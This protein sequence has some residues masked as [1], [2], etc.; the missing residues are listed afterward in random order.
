MKKI[1]V[2]DDLYAELINISEAMNTQPNAATASPYMYQIEDDEEVI[3][4]EGYG[5]RQEWVEHSSGD[6]QRWPHSEAGLHDMCDDLGI[7]WTEQWQIAA[8]NGCPVLIQEELR[9]QKVN[10]VMHEL[11]DIQVYMG[12]FFTKAACELHIKLNR[13]HYRNPRPFVTHMYRNPEMGIVQKFLR[14]LTSGDIIIQEGSDGNK[15]KIAK[16]DN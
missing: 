15:G 14:G 7:E 10:V 5:D 12:A 13:H 1:L 2:P 8:S 6:Y 4:E 3:T 11:K 16:E 9:K